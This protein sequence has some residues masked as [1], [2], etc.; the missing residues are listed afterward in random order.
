ML[1]NIQRQTQYLPYSL[2]R[3]MRLRRNRPANDFATFYE[4]HIASCCILQGFEYRKLCWPPLL[5]AAIWPFSVVC[6]CDS[7]PRASEPAAAGTGDATQRLRGAGRAT[8]SKKLR[9]QVCSMRAVQHACLH[10][11]RDN[12]LAGTRTR[13]NVLCPDDTQDLANLNAAELTPLTPEV[14]SR[15]AT[16]NIGE[17]GSCH[18]VCEHVVRQSCRSLQLRSC[19]GRAN[20]RFICRHNRPCGA[21]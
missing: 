13:A 1:L 18:G 10:T 14:I 16:I 5:P 15:Q 20:V 7:S 3:H 11:W 6:G 4:G 21:W 8:M 17:R 19:D 2:P 9:E 12:L